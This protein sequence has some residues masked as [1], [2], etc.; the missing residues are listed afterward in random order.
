[1]YDLGYS[2]MQFF[3][4]VIDFLS[5]KNRVCT[6][7]HINAILGGHEYTNLFKTPDQLGWTLLI[8]KSRIFIDEKRVYNDR[9]Y[10]TAL[11]YVLNHTNN[12]NRIE[13]EQLLRACIIELADNN[14]KAVEIVEA[15]LN[16]IQEEQ[17]RKG[18]QLSS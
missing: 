3:Q 6:P 16:E 9:D 10:T 2:V 5:G 15:L 1:M 4:D 11:L 8:G 17:R 7:S 12:I 13:D 18:N 14:L